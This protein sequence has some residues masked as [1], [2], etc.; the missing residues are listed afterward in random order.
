V[1][2]CRN[3]KGGGKN[4]AVSLVTACMFE[5]CSGEFGHIH[6]HH[7]DTGAMF[8]PGEQKSMLLL[9]TL[10]EGMEPSPFKLSQHSKGWP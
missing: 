5:I 10:L 9:P 4:P 1:L 6:Q 2:L 3:L 7:P 8:V